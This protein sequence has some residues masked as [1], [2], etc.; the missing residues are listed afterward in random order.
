MGHESFVEE[1]GDVTPTT[2]TGVLHQWEVFSSSASAYQAN[3]S[4]KSDQEEQNVEYPETD[5]QRR[6]GL[7]PTSIQ[8]DRGIPCSH[9]EVDGHRPTD[10]TDKQHSDETDP[11]AISDPPV[12]PLG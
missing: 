2:V 3:S 1:G 4:Y 12:D 6:L 11:E 8:S 7:E 10:D 5:N 9:A